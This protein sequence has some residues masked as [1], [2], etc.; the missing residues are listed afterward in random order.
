VRR[1]LD[2]DHAV[3]CVAKDADDYRGLAAKRLHRE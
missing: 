2:E 1:P 3:R